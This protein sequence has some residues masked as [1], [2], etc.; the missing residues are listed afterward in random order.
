MAQV[1]IDCL[2]K[3][4]SIIE[5]LVQNI[6]NA[7]ILIR[8]YLFQSIIQTIGHA[9]NR[10]NLISNNRFHLLFIELIE[11]DNQIKKMKNSLFICFVFIT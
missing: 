8:D 7:D 5:Y 10:V 1:Q 3:F 4:V 6:E 9:N 2:E 11:I